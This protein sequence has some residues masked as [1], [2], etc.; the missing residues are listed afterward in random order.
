MEAVRNQPG[1]GPVGWFS[2][3]PE[4]QQAE[5]TALREEFRAGNL[6]CSARTISKSI[7]AEIKIVKPYTV[8][9]WLLDAN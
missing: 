9:R 2:R 3:L 5:L 1:R 6:P 4:D 7:S 8:A